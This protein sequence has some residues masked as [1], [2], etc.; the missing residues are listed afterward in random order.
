LTSPLK[1][2]IA[3]PIPIDHTLTYLVPPELES[4]LR[5]GMRATVPVKAKVMTGFVCGLH[6]E[7]GRTGR[8]KPIKEI[9]DD[10]PVLDEHLLWLARWISGYYVAP[11]G[12][13]L[14]AMAPPRPKLRKVYSLRK[15]PGGLEMEILKV[16]HPR[17]AALI[18][19]L[20]QGRPVGLAAL[21]RK[22][23]NAGIKDDLR[24]LEEE[25]WISHELVTVKRRKSAPVAEE[26]QGYTGPAPF[27]HVLTPSQKAAYEGIKEAL[28]KGSFKPFLLYGVT[29]SGKTEVYLRA[30]DRAVS[31]GRKAIYLVPEIA[32]TPQIMERVTGRFGT[33]CAVLHSRISDAERHR[34]WTAIMA[35]RIDVVVGARSAVFA[36]LRDIGII[37]VD[38]EHDT[39]YKQQDSPRYNARDVAIRRGEQAGAVVVMGS[40]TPTLET[41]CRALDGI[42]GLYELPDRISGGTLPQVRVVDMRSAKPQSPFSG[43]ADKAIA[44]AFEENEQVLLFLN[45][46]GYSN[47]VQCRDCG[48]V[49]RCPSCNVTLTYHISHRDLKCHYCGHREG[50]WK[51]CPR[52]GGTDIVYVGAG[53]QRIEDHIAGSFPDA[54]LARFDRDSTR[55]KGSTENLLEDFSSGLVR[56]LVGTQ[57]VAKGHDFRRVGLVVVVNADI[58][59]NLPDFRSGERT[60][61]ILTQVAGRAGRGDIPGKVII[62]T[63]NPEHHSLSFVANHDFPGFYTQE[64]ALRRELRYPP[65]SRLVRVVA[66]SA[67]EQL[68]RDGAA[69]FARAASGMVDS[70]RSQVEV[71]G[72]SRAPISRIKQVYRW[73]LLLKGDPGEDL[74]GFVSMCLRRVRKIDAV[75][76]VRFSIDVDPQAMI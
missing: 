65:Y 53:T 6:R 45:R 44:A 71:I 40:A 55:R 66:E 42:Y 8:L 72:P 46:R 1:A 18:D 29:G 56:F 13:V 32:L 2:E 37:V 4:A 26:S 69:E 50:A 41:Y 17:R 49:P 33:R 62:Q 20:R 15:P 34:T 16:T 9:V 43:E 21:T 24:I 64:V 52:C 22:L 57:M 12:E 23:G 7:P 67:R 59:M 25:G 48:I 61:Q 70:L 30:I 74:S 35:G 47:Y 58:S 39:S 76:R 28:D 10:A 73:H 27:E 75:E 68:A 31:R 63:F 51:A 36:P 3:V 60:F 5:V 11:I 54:A 19:S 38:E 14:A